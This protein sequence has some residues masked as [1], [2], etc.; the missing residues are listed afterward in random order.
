MVHGSGHRPLDR[1]LRLNDWGNEATQ[2]MNDTQDPNQA[3]RDLQ[4]AALAASA[5]IIGCFVVYWFLQIQDVREML[6]LAYD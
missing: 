4:L 2:T 6:A 5:T 3:S 1:V